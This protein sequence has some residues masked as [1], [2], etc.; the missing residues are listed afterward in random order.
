MIK[1]QQNKSYTQHLVYH[2]TLKIQ[3]Y[4]NC[5]LLHA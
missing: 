3:K 2:T 5:A 4:F 1:I